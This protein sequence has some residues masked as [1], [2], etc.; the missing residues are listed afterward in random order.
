[1]SAPPSF[2]VGAYCSDF[3]RKDLLSRAITCTVRPLTS[4]RP[5]SSFTTR[6]FSPP[7]LSPPR[8]DLRLMSHAGW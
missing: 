7:T 5:V 8:L 3:G 1:M 2:F 6:G 4:C